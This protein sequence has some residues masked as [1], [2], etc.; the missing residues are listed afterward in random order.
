MSKI[1]KIDEARKVETPG[2]RTMHWLVDWELGATN[3][4]VVIYDFEPGYESRRVHYHERRESAYIALKGSG[5]V[6]LNGEQHPM[7]PETVVYLSPGDVH[8]VVAAGEDGFSM[9]EVWSPLERDT[10]YIEDGN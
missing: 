9:I 7:E 2:E 3:M 6:H 5:T 8:G 10:I 1:F 4:N